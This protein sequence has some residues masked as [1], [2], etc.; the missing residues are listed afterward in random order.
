MYP[1]SY[2]LFCISAQVESGAFYLDRVPRVKHVAGP[3]FSEGTYTKNTP[4]EVMKKKGVRGNLFDHEMHFSFL[5]FVGAT[6]VDMCFLRGKL[7]LGIAFKYFPF[8]FPY[9]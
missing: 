4:Q 7:H 3:F 9:V 2:G 6:L 8:Y 1:F 5:Y